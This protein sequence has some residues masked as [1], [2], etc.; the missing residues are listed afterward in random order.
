LLQPYFRNITKRLTKHP[1]LYFTDTG[2]AAYLA[3]WTTPKS[4]ETGVSSGAF[5]E[6]F[7]II[8]IVKSY[9]HNGKNPQLYF[10]KDSEPP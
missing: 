2:L 7:V 10:Y 6:T 3:G 5:F 8:E 1:K 4:L 9:Y